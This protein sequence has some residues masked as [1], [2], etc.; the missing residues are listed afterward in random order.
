VLKGA[1]F[2]ITFKKATYGNKRHVKVKDLETKQER[3]ELRETVVESIRKR[4]ACKD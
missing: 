2:L 4:L 3:D 1:R